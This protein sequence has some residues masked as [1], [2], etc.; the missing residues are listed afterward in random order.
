MYGTSMLRVRASTHARPAPQ[1]AIEGHDRHQ[2]LGGA[3]QY[4]ARTGVEAGRFAEV[5]RPVLDNE[6]AEPAR[7][8]ALKRSGSGALT[9]LHVRARRSGDSR[10]S[11]GA[12]ASTSHWRPRAVRTWPSRHVL[13]RVLRF[14]ADLGSTAT[15]RGASLRPFA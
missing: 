10:C 9:A 11:P 4:H 5:V 2:P 1:G 13:L 3:R 6:G 8:R 15:R 7:K 14:R 12:M